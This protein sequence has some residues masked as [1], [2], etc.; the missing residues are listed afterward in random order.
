MHAISCAYLS[1]QPFAS[2]KPLWLNTKHVCNEVKTSFSRCKKSH[3]QLRNS[4]LIQ[5]FALRFYS[6][7]G[8]LLRKYFYEPWDSNEQ[9]WKERS[10]HP[11]YSNLIHFDCAQK[12]FWLR[13]AKKFPWK[14]FHDVKLKL[15]ELNAPAA[16]NEIKT[17]AQKKAIQNSLQNHAK[18]NKFLFPS[19]MK[20]PGFSCLF[21]QKLLHHDRAVS[22]KKEKKLQICQMVRNNKRR[23]GWMEKQFPYG[24]L[25]VLHVVKS[26]LIG[27]IELDDSLTRWIRNFSLK[28]HTMTLYQLR[29]FT[30]QT[31]VRW[32]NFRKSALWMKLKIHR[33][34]MSSLQG[35]RLLSIPDNQ[36]FTADEEQSR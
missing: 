33:Y 29:C 8:L 4:R 13:V 32:E 35:A 22:P 23:E 17:A 12:A 20:N 28:R 16:I 34:R 31:L 2:L 27:K 26:Q 1:L 25:N 19:L 7:Q 14:T 9:R 10:F 24:E 3:F 15:T 36:I 18:F 11:K 5:Q 6:V 21:S 30:L